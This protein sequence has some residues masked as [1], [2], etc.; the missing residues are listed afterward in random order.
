MLHSSHM[1]APLSHTMP[2]VKLDN[3]SECLDSL[4]VFS[5][6]W[7]LGATCDR[8]SAAKFDA[9]LRQLLVGKVQAAVDRT[10]VDLGPGLAIRY[11][12]QLYAVVLPEVRVSCSLLL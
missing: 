3:P 9:F 11:P 2:Q 4:F 8:A 10:D 5:L 6:V 12:E 7:S 1:Y